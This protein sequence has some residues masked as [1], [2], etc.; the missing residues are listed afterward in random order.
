MFSFSINSTECA[1]DLIERRMV[2]EN[3]YQIVYA[4]K[5]ECSIS[6][7]TPLVVLMTEHIG[8][9]SE[10]LPRM[11]I[12]VIKIPTDNSCREIQRRTNS[13]KTDKMKLLKT[14]VASL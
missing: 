5:K 13:D 11:P 2:K 10:N 7:P 14:F 4:E 1:E 6:P 8:N 3:V 12:E 9:K